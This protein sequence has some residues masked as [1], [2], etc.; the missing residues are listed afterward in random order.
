LTPP[1]TVQDKT[2]LSSSFVFNKRPRQA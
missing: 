1:K 2:K